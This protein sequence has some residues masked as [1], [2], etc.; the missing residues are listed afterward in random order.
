[1]HSVYGYST[2]EGHMD[3]IR[4]T[5]DQVNNVL[6][7]EDAPKNRLEVRLH[8]ELMGFVVYDTPSSAEAREIFHQR[9]FSLVLIHFSVDPLQGLSLCRWI[10]AASNI[11]IIMFT[12][13]GE[14]VDESMVMTAGAD[15][16]VAMPTD[17]KILSS[18]VVQ[19]MNRGKSQRLPRANILTW[20]NM[21][22]DLS[23]HE[24]KVGD[25]QLHLTNT[26]F[27]FLQLLL[28][29]PK[30]IFTRNQILEAIGVMKG[31]GS[32]QLV[33]THASRLRKKIR[34]SGG[35]EIISVVRS[36][37][38]RLV[39]SSHTAGYLVPDEEASF[40][41]EDRLLAGTDIPLSEH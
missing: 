19:Q 28:E 10:R 13:R 2:Q 4:E 33:D 18:R 22:M 37:G 21:Q 40:P 7:V 35:P 11:P 36:V 29:N 27:Q 25:K 32:N 41:D 1:M 3:D 23:N 14:L 5:A 20:E 15:D 26:E 31:V 17:S 38:F 16:Y 8:L 12:K 6:L 34:D 39:D 30:R 9:D 24:F